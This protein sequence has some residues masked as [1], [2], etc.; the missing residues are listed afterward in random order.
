MEKMQSGKETLIFKENIC[1]LSSEVQKKRNP[2]GMKLSF[3]YA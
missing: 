3:C 2:D 1:F